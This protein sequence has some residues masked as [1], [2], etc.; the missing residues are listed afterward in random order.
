VT[1]R[2]IR[3]VVVIP[4]VGTVAGQLSAFKRGTEVCHKLGAIPGLALGHLVSQPRVATAQ[5]RRSTFWSSDGAIASRAI[6]APECSMLHIDSPYGCTRRCKR[7][8]RARRAPCRAA[9]SL[10]KV[11]ALVMKPRAAVVAKAPSPAASSA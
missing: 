4:L 3:D 1:R 10:L 7:A 2:K 6:F 9:G 8:P 5:L 11:V